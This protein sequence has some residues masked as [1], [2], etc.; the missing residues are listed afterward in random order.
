MHFSENHSGVFTHHSGV[1]T[2]HSGV[3]TRRA[4]IAHPQGHQCFLQEAAPAHRLFGGGLISPALVMSFASNVHSTD[5]LCR[6]LEL[7]RASSL[8]DIAAMQQQVQEI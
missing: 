8:P 2:H 6:G 4:E 1:F 5:T 7:I 3:F